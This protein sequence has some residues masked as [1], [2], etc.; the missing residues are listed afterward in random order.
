L[1]PVCHFVHEGTRQSI[2]YSLCYS[3]RID[4]THPFDRIT[5]SRGGFLIARKL[6]HIRRRREKYQ[7][8][9]IRN[10]AF[11]LVTRLLAPDLTVRH[12]SSIS[13]GPRSFRHI[14]LLWGLVPKSLDR[15]LTP[16]TTKMPRRALPPTA[17][18][19][20]DTLLPPPPPSPL[21]QKLRQDYRWASISQFCWT[22]SDAFGLV[23]WDIDVSFLPH[24]PAVHNSS[25][26]SSTSSRLACD[27]GQQHEQDAWL[28]TYSNVASGR[29]RRE[30]MTE[31]TVTAARG[32]LR[33]R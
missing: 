1:I 2:L 16:Q 26:M 29:S 27:R 33:R 24:F 32:R 11:N 19:A 18:A 28:S 6:P 21:I 31:L 14:L 22:F 23:D 13:T 10:K 5:S 9:I 12:R 17:V 3:V 15:Q 8:R 20:I 4:Y 7:N 30:R 25:A